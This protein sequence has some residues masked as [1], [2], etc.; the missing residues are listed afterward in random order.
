[1][2]QLG[3][4]EQKAADDVEDGKEEIDVE[5]TPTKI[6]NFK[7]AVEDVEKFLERRGCIE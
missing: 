4:E 7:E 5:S 2:K 3:Q 6:Q 1:M